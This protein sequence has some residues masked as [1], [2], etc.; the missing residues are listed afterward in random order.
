VWHG[1][2]RQV[3]AVPLAANAREFLR[4]EA[5]EL[6]GFDLPAEALAEAHRE[7]WLLPRASRY[8]KWRHFD[9]EAWRLCGSRHGRAGG[10][11]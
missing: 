4:G 11:S 2:E 8:D 9:P 7:R 10:G 6:L 3:F 1:V 5:E